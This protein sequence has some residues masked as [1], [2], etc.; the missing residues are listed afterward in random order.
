M[1]ARDKEHSL[2]DVKLSLF[3]ICGL[4]QSLLGNY[5]SSTVEFIRIY[6]IA[7]YLYLSFFST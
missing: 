2:N 5:K 1:C 4:S 7:I 3:Y 6:K